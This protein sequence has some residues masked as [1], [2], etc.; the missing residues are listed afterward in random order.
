MCQCEC[1]CGSV[2]GTRVYLQDTAGWLVSENGPWVI[3][4]G[5]AYPLADVFTQRPVTLNIP[6]KRRALYLL[7]K[8]VNSKF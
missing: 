4:D 6:C 1:V 7:S 5:Q 8:S 3:A 2:C